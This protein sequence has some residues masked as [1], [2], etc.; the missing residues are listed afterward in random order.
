[1]HGRIAKMIMVWQTDSAPCCHAVVVDG[2]PVLQL[3]RVMARINLMKNSIL[4]Q[5]E[6]VVFA[7]H[8]QLSVEDDVERED[9]RPQTS[10]DHVPLAANAFRR[11]RAPAARL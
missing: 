1:M 5:P 9:Y 11:R 6:L 2:E 3:G 4:T 7:S 10:I 8:N